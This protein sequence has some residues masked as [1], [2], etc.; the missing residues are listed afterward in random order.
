MARFFFHF[1]SKDDA[2]HDSNGR[3]FSDL[4]EAH[5]HALTLIRKVVLLD[6]KDWR[7]WSVKISD[8]ENK[9][10]LSVLFPHASILSTGNHRLINRDL[11]R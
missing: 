11:S 8:A 10:T 6:D 7:G 4:G 3:E 9:S 5:R 2:V 1:M